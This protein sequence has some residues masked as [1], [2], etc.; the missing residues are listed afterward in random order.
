MRLAITLAICFTAI[1]VGYF[2]ILDQK[3][4]K[5]LPILNPTDLEYDMVDTSQFGVGV[6]HTI[7]EFKFKN[8]YDKWISNEEVDGKVYVAEYFFTTCKTICPIMN[9]EMKRVQSSLKGEKDFKILSFTVDPEVDDVEA[10]KYYAESHQ[11]IPGKWHFLTGSKK[12]LYQ[13][14]RSSYFIL[15]PAEAANLGDAGSDFIHTNNFILVDRS[16]RIRG[17]Y[18]GTSTKEVDQLIRDVK[19]LLKE[20]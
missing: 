14:A 8:Q 17:Y 10:M 5:S 13:L 9:S 19:L 4:E 7:D 2:M 12:D 1:T 20:K 11:A 15:K 16:S 3:V 6:G 18:D